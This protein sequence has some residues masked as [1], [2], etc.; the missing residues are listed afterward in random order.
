MSCSALI[1]HGGNLMFVLFTLALSAFA[2]ESNTV[3]TS[4]L[5]ASFAVAPDENGMA[6]VVADLT[7]V[8]ALNG[9]LKEEPVTL[10]ADETI[11]FAVNGTSINYSSVDS[12]KNV[13]PLVE[14]GTYAM[15]FKRATGESYNSAVKLPD[16][17]NFTSPAPQAQFK[18]ADTVVV[19][20]LDVP[21][22]MSILFLSSNC[23]IGGVGVF[24][25]DFTEMELPGGWASSCAG[26]VSVDLGMMNIIRG[27]GFGSILGASV[28]AVNFSYDGQTRAS[29]MK[30]PANL[31]LEALKA[32]KL[33]SKSTIVLRPL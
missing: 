10:S 7:R 25:D 11:V 17:A 21:H 29:K 2:L 27:Q 19:K 23:S 18:K 3:P 30:L 16:S 15:N 20:W 5:T 32:L 14:G 9:T 13:L 26:P 24:N 1:F 4:Q 6:S 22:D 33:G 31:G 28:S 8:S 12:S